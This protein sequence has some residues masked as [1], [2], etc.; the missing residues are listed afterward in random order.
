MKQMKLTLEE[1]ILISSDCLATYPPEDFEWKLKTMEDRE[2]MTLSALHF[3]FQGGLEPSRYRISC[4]FCDKSYPEDVD[5]SIELLG[6]HT[7]EN[8]VL[9]AKSLELFKQ[10]GLERFNGHS[11][12]DEVT[13]NRERTLQ[14]LGDWRQQA[15]AYRTSHL[16]DSYKTI[17]GLME[18][19]TACSSCLQ[20]LH[21][22]C[23]L[24]NMEWINKDVLNNVKQMENW[25]H[26]CSGCGMCES[27]CPEEF[28]LFSVILFLSKAR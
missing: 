9:N 20:T 11:V 17:E 10:L 13:L 6:I 12:P 27:D 16:D 24:F 25:L 8:L 19:L 14:R 1:R 18:H 4:Q 2:Q 28:P 22:C 7:S 21:E 23:P 26:T 5:L 3:A 15:L